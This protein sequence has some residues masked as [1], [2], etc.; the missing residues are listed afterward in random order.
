MILPPRIVLVRPKFSGNV[1]ASARAMGNTGLP[2]LR[3]VAPADDPE[4]VHGDEHA[5]WS[6]AASGGD[7]LR[8]AIRHASVAEAVA[9]C[10]VVIA[11]TARP[12]AFKAWP[13]V[14]P[15]AAAELLCAAG[16][17]GEPSALLFG[18]ED[19]G[20]S[21]DDL[22]QATHLCQ[23]PTGGVASSLNLAQS[24]LLLGWEWGK[25]S[26][27]LS[28][29]PTPRAG[30]RPR[31]DVA[32]VDGLAEQLGDLLERIDFFRRRGRQQSLVTLRQA[33]L[34]GEL[35]NVEV[36]FLRGLARK[37]EWHLDH[38]GQLKAPA[39]PPADGGGAPEPSDPPSDDE[40]SAKA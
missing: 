24:V 4:A 2:D 9:G 17:D 14:G 37:L 31:A 6:M 7:V 15:E 12:R 18:P 26:R 21:T 40:P 25:A 5:A 29:R 11:C 32:Q 35:T 30:R 28:R 1:G 34:R 38:P 19:H 13:N 20:L 23:I 33:L 36:H 27:A 16:R 39:A 3:L 8:A 10:T 22:E